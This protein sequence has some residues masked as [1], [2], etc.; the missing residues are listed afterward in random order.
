VSA[1]WDTKLWSEKRK[2]GKVIERKG[3]FPSALPKKKGEAET[4]SRTGFLATDEEEVGST[5]Y[6]QTP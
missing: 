5:L 6:D 2:K 4:S 3:A 1:D